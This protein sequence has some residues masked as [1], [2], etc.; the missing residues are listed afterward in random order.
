MNNEEV[1]STPE[2][3]SLAERIYVLP[4]QDE[5]ARNEMRIL[6]LADGNNRAS[7]DNKSYDDGGKNVIKV[8]EHLSTRDEVSL[9][10]ACIL[11][12]DNIRKRPPHF[13]K[14]IAHAFQLLSQ[15]I[16]NKGTLVDAGVRMDVYGDIEAMEGM[17][18][19]DAQL[20]DEIRRACDKTARIKDPSLL[21]LL[22]VNYDHDMAYNLG[23]H[24]IYRSGMDS[25]G[26]QDMNV[27]RSSN[28]NVHSGILNFASE[29]LWPYVGLQEIDEVVDTV[30]HNV[31]RFFRMGYDLPETVKLVAMFDAADSSLQTGPAELSIP[32]ACPTPQLV[33]ALE[34]HF[35]EKPPAVSIQIHGMDKPYKLGPDVG[36]SY[37]IHLIHGSHVDSH[38]TYDSILAPGQRQNY[39][40]LPDRPPISYANVFQCDA[41]RESIVEAIQRILQFSQHH[42][43]L[44]GAERTPSPRDLPEFM[45]YYQSADL[46]YQHPESSLEELADDLLENVNSEEKEYSLQHYNKVA[47]LFAGSIV[48]WS[49]KAGIPWPSAPAFRAFINYVFTSFF[50]AY[51]P[52]HPDWEDS[53]RQDWQKRAEL[54]SKYMVLTYA[55][56]DFIFDIP[57][58]DDTEKDQFLAKSSDLLR[59]AIRQEDISSDEL[60]GHPEVLIILLREFR[61]LAR[62]LEQDADPHAFKRWEEGMT[63]IVECMHGEWLQEVT[64]NCFPS[65]LRNDGEAQEAFRS[66]YLHEKIP[67]PVRSKIEDA[68]QRYQQ[69]D[70]DD[71][72]KVEADLRLYMYLVDIEKSIGSGNIYKTMACIGSRHE[73]LTEEML[74]DLDL[75]CALINYYFRIAND[76]AEFSRAADDRDDNVSSLH[77]IADKY[78]GQT[79]AEMQCFQDIYGVMTSLRSD[80]YT[81]IERFQKQY[82]GSVVFTALGI[83]LQRARIGE[84]FYK[85]THYRETRRSQVQ[86]FFTELEYCGIKEL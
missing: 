16:E 66:R 8:A 1:G 65:H 63:D 18:D 34:R 19:A 2:I 60:E 28:I 27:F 39:I 78:R 44:K 73:T 37:A 58:E 40:R 61:N 17:G 35:S 10:A 46:L 68:Y 22:G 75:L 77:I 13:K 41:T 42:D 4:T 70:G 49:E 25:R 85:G 5:V 53:L 76:L 57:P 84:L 20:V 86:E 79:N 80:L 3:E 54:L 69:S 15:R 24:A 33:H 64:Q 29:T 9:M 82:A 52:N 83:A 71:V 55:M 38:K 51:Y 30:R 26:F 59:R 56:D 6:I 21:L 11:G 62:A 36:T 31:S 47:D 14:K 43:A 50:F 45:P 48:Q 7:L 67:V 72:T 74:E 12:P 81:E 23:I 32:Y